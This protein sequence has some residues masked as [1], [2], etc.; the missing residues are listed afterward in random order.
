LHIIDKY[1]GLSISG[2]W[3]AITPILLSDDLYLAC[4]G[5]DLE[6]RWLQIF[7]GY[8]YRP[9]ITLAQIGGKVFDDGQGFPSPDYPQVLDA[10]I[11]VPGNGLS[12]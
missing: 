10:L 9:G 5:L 1:K 12:Q 2:G 6:N 11:V 7:N 4:L 3:P 8:R